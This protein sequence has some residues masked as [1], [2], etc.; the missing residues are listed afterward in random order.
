APMNERE[1]QDMMA[2]AAGY[3]NG[4]FAIR[5]PRGE[6]QDFLHDRKPQSIEIGKGEILVEGE[7]I[8][9]LTIGTIG[10]EAKK[11]VNQLD[12]MGVHV[13]HFNMRFVKPLDTELLDHIATTYRQ[14]ITV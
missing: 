12:K 4:A 14:I 7:D 5:Y 11:A 13:G 8:A 2:T 9:I 1:L 3:E 10:N 6:V